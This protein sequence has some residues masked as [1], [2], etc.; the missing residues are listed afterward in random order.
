M[1]NLDHNPDTFPIAAIAASAA[2]PA[3]TEDEVRRLEQAL[4]NSQFD[5]LWAHCLEANIGGLQAPKSVAA[6]TI[7]R[8]NAASASTAARE[9]SLDQ[10]S[11]DE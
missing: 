11:S 7:L 6:G 9:G 10:S 2:E 5:A 8:A 1:K 3:M 4:N